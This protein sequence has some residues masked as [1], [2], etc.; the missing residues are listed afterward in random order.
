[1]L[2]CKHISGMAALCLAS[3]ITCVNAYAAQPG[4]YLGAQGGWANL[5]QMGISSADMDTLISNA[6]FINNFTRTSFNGTTSGNGAGWRVFG[7]YQ[8]GYNWAA[9]IGWAV[10]PNLPINATA[11]GVHNLTGDPFHVATSGTFQTSV[12]DLVGKYIRPL[13]CNFN[14]Y[15]KL[16]LAL[17]VGRSNE[18]A[19][20][21][22]SDILD[23]FTFSEFASESDKTSRLFPTFGIGVGYDFRPDISAD[24]SYNRIQKVGS[25]EELGSIDFFSLSLGFHFG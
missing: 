1:M 10:Y 25:S 19:Q 21:I 11:A 23:G 7:G 3:L 2:T 20:V 15:G 18:Q 6:I 22:T 5:N 8:L 14:I 12:F 4:L 16:G 9:E 17:V 24:V 13:P